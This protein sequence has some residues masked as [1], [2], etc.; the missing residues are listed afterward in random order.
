M[1]I[2]ALAK[3]YFMKEL[4]RN[5]DLLG[6]TATLVSEVFFSRAKNL[7]VKEDSKRQVKGNI[8]RIGL[9]PGIV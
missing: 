2:R 5:L 3:K 7:G 9:V 6:R 4:A 1:K 8:L